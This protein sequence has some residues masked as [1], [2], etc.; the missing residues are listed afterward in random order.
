MSV[1]TL[2]RMREVQGQ[3]RGVIHP[4]PLQSSRTF[5]EMTGVQ[6][7]LKPEC[8]LQQLARH[9]QLRYKVFARFTASAHRRHCH[10]ASGRTT[11]DH[12]DAGHAG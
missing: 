7:Y 5:S 12:A 10:L 8:F 11:Q 2:E 1:I 4:T 3:L 9:D 6:V